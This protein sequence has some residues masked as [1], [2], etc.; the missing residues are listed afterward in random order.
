M[1]RRLL[2]ALKMMAAIYISKATPLKDLKKKKLLEK[3]EGFEDF[4]IKELY[5]N[6]KT[7]LQIDVDMNS[8]MEFNYDRGF[9]PSI[10]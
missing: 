2:L 5:E 10:L 9:V 1:R 7:I 8:K 3:L 6:N 4:K